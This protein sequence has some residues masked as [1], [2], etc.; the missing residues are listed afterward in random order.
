[1]AQ[2]DVIYDYGG[3]ASTIDGILKDHHVLNKILDLINRR[4]VL[5]SRLRTNRTTHGRQ[6]ILSVQMGTSQGVGARRENQ[7]L[8]NPGWGEYEQAHGNVKYLYS[9]LHITGPAIESTAG[10][11]AAYAS[12]LKQA[13]KDCRDGLMLDM[14]RQVWGDGTGAIGVVADDVTGSATVEVTDPYG[15]TY[16]ASDPL[17]PDQCVR[18]FKRNMNLTITDGTTTVFGTVRSVNPGAGTITLDAPIT[19]G[20]G[21][22]IYRGDEAGL[23]NQDG[24]LLGLS[25]AISAT[26]TYLGIDRDGKP[27]WQSNLLDLSDS[28]S[29]EAIRS[30][31]DLTEIN[32]TGEPDLIITDYVT[33]RRYEALLQAQKRFVNPME[34][35]GGFKALEFDGLPIVVDKDAP[36][37]RMWFLRTSDWSWYSMRDIGWLDRHGAVLHPVPDFDAWKA[38]LTTYREL[39]CQRPN[40]QTVMFNITG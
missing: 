8:P 29:E 14:Q 9:T 27:E 33:R 23:T 20:A 39:V 32:G 38:Y 15:L 21:A 26:G 4:T 11:K 3:P 2:R 13:L 36:P 17:T 10:N 31:L 12:A 28:I 40:N 1:M 19:I 16:D 24:E 30:A 7:R 37:Q 6:F 18:L 25:G 35:E 34:L 22:R 5:F